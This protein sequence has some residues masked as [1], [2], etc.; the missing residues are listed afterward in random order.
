M[1]I[2]EG[3][4]AIITGASSGIGR[5]CAVR[6]A[7][8][9]ASIVVCARR[10]E[11]LEEL[12]AEIEAKG[13]KVIAVKCDVSKEEDISAVVD[14]CINEFGKVDILLNNAQGGMNNQKYFEQTTPD[15]MEFAFVTGPLQSFRFIQKCL[16][17]MKKEHY[18]RIIN[19]ASQSALAGS[20]GFSAYET[21][22]GATMAITRNAAQE[23]GKYGIT[24]NCFLPVVKTEA[25]DM[26]EQGI[27]AA[28]NFAN[29]IPLKYFGNSYEDCSPI[30]AFMA[31]EKAGYM[32][33]QFIAI[34]G[35]WMPIA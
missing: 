9:G 15:D 30:V 3:R 7:E 4:I 13:G 31:S 28:N 29:I 35:G 25:Y 26:S 24:T 6:F 34:D 23:L 19:V 2:L 33:S 14:S 12:K 27:A 1:G 16:P 18:G 21:A 17:Y 11:K 10:L 22:K 20:P 5:A 8:E 32:N